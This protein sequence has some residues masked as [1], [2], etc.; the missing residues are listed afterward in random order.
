MASCMCNPKRCVTFASAPAVSVDGML[1]GT[2]RPQESDIS[3]N[4][5]AQSRVVTWRFDLSEYT[6]RTPRGAMQS[7]V[8]REPVVFPQEER[9][10]CSRPACLEREEGKGN[11]SSRPLATFVIC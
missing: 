4:T 5:P 8:V 11:R 3:A 1:P 2:P 6:A 7:D 9:I 10:V